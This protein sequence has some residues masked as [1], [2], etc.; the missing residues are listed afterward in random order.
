MKQF[1]LQFIFCLYGFLALSQNNPEPILILWN[2]QKPLTW[3]NFRG[4]VKEDEI[5]GDAETVYS[6]E[7]IPTD[8]LVDEDDNIVNY[9]DLSVAT[10]FHTDRSWVY[11]RNTLL[12]KY[13]R[14]KFDI[15]ELHARLMRKE[16][17]KL[18]DY[19]TTGFNDYQRVY[20]VYWNK[21][22]EMQ[23]E[24]NSDTHRGLN[25]DALVTWED[26]VYAELQLLEAYS[27]HP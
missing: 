21:C 22:R 26:K 7:I 8:I 23:R 5:I 18:K 3:E 25:A 11:D 17:Q 12:L 15:A 19:K 6:I 20:T 16:F 4:E 13:Q 27:L 2:E 10:Y 9:E 1:F 14:L 24:S